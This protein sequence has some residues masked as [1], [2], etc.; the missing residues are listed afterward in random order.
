MYLW[1]LGRDTTGSFESHEDTTK[2]RAN[3]RSEYQH[4]E[5]ERSDDDD[6][7]LSNS[8]LLKMVFRT[9]YGRSL[10]FYTFTLSMGISV[11]D[12]LAFIFFDSLGASNRM[13]GMT[14]L[15]TTVF[16]T[17]VFYIAPLLLAKWGPGK[18]L[19]SAGVAYIIRVV[20][21]T[22]VPD[23]TVG[24]SIIL[25]LETLHGL[26]YAGSKTGSVEFIA[27]IIPEG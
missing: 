18:L 9:N 19:L 22:L 24:M 16:E 5:T 13:D 15:F 8:E 1:G 2:E 20:G 11:V 27:Q 17:P 3:G 14:V 6:D 25:A 4:E 10:L 26:T 23:G 21:Y 12:N 7:V